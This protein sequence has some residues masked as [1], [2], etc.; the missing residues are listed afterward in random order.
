MELRLLSRGWQVPGT[1]AIK[2][3]EACYAYYGKHPPPA[4]LAAP[5]PTAA[6][7]APQPTAALSS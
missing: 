5:Q 2:I 1:D 6:L 4:A 7:A 3:E